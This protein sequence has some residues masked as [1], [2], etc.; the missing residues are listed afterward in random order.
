MF[1]DLKN[2]LLTGREKHP[3]DHH[4]QVRRCD[5][6]PGLKVD[7]WQQI[8]LAE[9]VPVITKDSQMAD[10]LANPEKYQWIMKG[11]VGISRICRLTLNFSSYPYPRE[12]HWYA[13]AT[14]EIGEENEYLLFA[15]GICPDYVF[16]PKSDGIDPP[17]WNPNC[18]S[19]FAILYS[20]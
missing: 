4:Y 13:K 16:R 12:G 2:R 11:N 8:P 9:G 6:K 19:S 7:A 5:V 20:N 10:A 17:G 15:L 1:E 18:K 3:W 14:T